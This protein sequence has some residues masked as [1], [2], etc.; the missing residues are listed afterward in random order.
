MSFLGSDVSR[1]TE[2]RLIAFETE[3]LKWA[4][5]INLVAPSTLNDIRQR[6]I[7][8]SA[9]IFNCAPDTKT[10]IDLG[11]G[12]GFPGLVLAVLLAD[13]P[14]SHVHMVES[15]GKKCAFLRHM[16][17][18]LRLAATVHNARIE[19]VIAGLPTPDIVTARALVPLPLLLQLAAPQLMKNVPAYFHKGREHSQE[20][21]AAR[22]KYGFDLLVHNSR[23]DSDSVILEIRNLVP[24]AA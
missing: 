3:F 5:R 12:G 13:K 1:E 19:D 18:T 2:T 24:L 7:A 23:I 4:S 15:N 16:I 11:S 6:H 22:G 10:I 14:G 17:R 20:I 8:D 21:E 9:Q